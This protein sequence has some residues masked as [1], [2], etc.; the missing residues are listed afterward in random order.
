MHE[1]G[2]AAIGQ[3]FLDARTPKKWHLSDVEEGRLKRLHDLVRMGPTSNN[4]S[5][6]R[7]VFVRSTVARRSLLRAIHSGN[8]PKVVDVAVIAII[9]YDEA[10]WRHWQRLSPHKDLEAT[11]ASSPEKAAAEARTSALLQAG[12]FILAARALGLDVLPLTGFDPSAVDAN[13]L[14]DGWKPLMLCCLGNG[15]T[16]ALRPRA[17]RLEYEDACRLV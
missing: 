10:F 11:F 15:D 7:F 1:V 4:G 6:A 16:S 9:C 12:Y 14:R 5:P 17:A 3:I 13:F 8:Q 2:D